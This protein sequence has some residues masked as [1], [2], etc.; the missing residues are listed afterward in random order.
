VRI[1]R[2]LPISRVNGPGMRF[3][4]WVQGCTRRCSGCF[5][6]DTHAKD[7]GYELSIHEIVNQI[8]LD[9]INGITISGGEPF[10]QA[11]EL[12]VLLEETYEKKI[13]S[14][15]YTGFTYEELVAQKNKIIEKCLGLIDILIDGAYNKEMPPNLPWTGSGNQRI[16]RL[17]RG[18]IAT[19]CKKEDVELGNGIWGEVIIDRKGGITITGIISG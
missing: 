15:V 19:I 5:N 7:G 13:N 4:V 17:K 9:E 12:A 3:V 2:I 11:G 1:H 18:K 8:P 6:P 16:L 14:L 10:E